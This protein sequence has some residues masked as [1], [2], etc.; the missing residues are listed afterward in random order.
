MVILWNWKYTKTFEKTLI[1]IQN[2]L[3]GIKDK[4]FPNFVNVSSVGDISKCTNSQC[5]VPSDKLGWYVNLVNKQKLTAEPTVD[6]DRVYFPIY[7]PSKRSKFMYNWK[8]YFNCL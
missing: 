5:P 7:E 4:D 1:Q 3:F 8:G 2:R 6:K